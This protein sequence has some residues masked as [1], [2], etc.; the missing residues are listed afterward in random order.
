MST[1]PTNLARVPNMLV[2]QIMLSTLS[3][4]Q[5][6]LLN[7]EIQLATGKAVNRASDDVLAGGTIAVLDDVIERRS[8]WIRNLSHAD[9]ILAGIDTAL[10][11]ASE[12]MLEAKGLASSQVGIGSD[13]ETRENQATVIDSMI[14]Q[15]LAIANQKFQDVHFF[16]G[17]STAA[18]PVQ[19]LLGGLR[20]TGTGEGLTTDIGQFIS[21]GVTMSGEEAF[22]ALSA[23]V[24]GNV[25]LGPAM[26]GATRLLDLNGARGL[27]VAL[28]SINVDVGGTDLTVDLSTAYTVQDAMTTLQTQIQTI[29]P[30]ATVSISAGGNAFSIT[31]SALVSIT[32]S[33]LG[34][35]ATAA[36]L[37]IAQ[38]FPAG[39]TTDG[40]DVD[41]RLTEL[42]P[43]STFTGVAI[44]MGTIRI[45]NAGQT[46]DVDLSG[47]TTVQD[48][49]NAVKA[50]NIG[51]R[52][53]IADTGDRLNFI[54]ELSGGSMS[55]GEVAGGTT[56]TELGVR[57]LAPWTRLEDFN[58]GRGVQILSGNV[59]PITGLPDPALDLDFRIT[60]KDGSFIDVDLAGAETVQDVLDAVNAASGIAGVPL[61]ADLAPDGNGIRI[62][63]GVLGPGPTTVTRL[64]GSF[65]AEDLGILGSTTG[66]SLTGDDRATAA[67]DSVFSHLIALRDALQT[68][69]ER[70]IT[71]A[72]ERFERDISR[73]AEARADV[74]VRA[75]RVADATGREEDLRIQDMSLRSQFQ[76]LDFTEAAIRYSTLQ[77]QLQAGLLTMSRV[78]SLSLLDFLQ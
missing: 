71:F 53:E 26:T 12:L 24:T 58:D 49:M 67:V 77:Q 5:Q 17:G 63:D 75:R 27:G 64:N 2:S 70:G 72:A 41:P 25:D 31:T 56:A 48:V 52:V 45:G 55:I 28:G 65:A 39:A 60:L 46:R 19:E 74:G 13:A 73:L 21:I 57:T 8:Q 66:A 18:P 51:V 9:S 32:I 15:I 33:D 7:T 29:D 44:P 11:D 54:N 61:T 4:A 34:A 69:D 37:G 43:V 20:Y 1:I 23:R 59:D 78:G 14:R 30:A 35:A 22:G 42:S 38:V 68:N 47:A 6:G 10:G 16:G 62:N 50:I 40:S 36:D 76:D 3:R